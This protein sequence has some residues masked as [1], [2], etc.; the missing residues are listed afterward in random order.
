VDIECKRPL[1][2]AILIGFGLQRSFYFFLF[3]I[4]FSF[5]A[6]IIY[7]Y[8]FGLAFLLH[9]AIGKTLGKRRTKSFHFNFCVRQTEK[10][11]QISTF[12]FF[13][14]MFVFFFV[15]YVVHSWLSEGFYF[16]LCLFF[17]VH[18]IIFSI[19]ILM[20]L[21]FLNFFFFAHNDY[22]QNG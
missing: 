1:P 14:F 13:C 18:S 5:F 21:V 16:Y 9:I 3:F 4:C 17:C 7:L 20:A 19:G 8:C 12:F 10:E 2:N 11:A 6:I 22:R 15:C